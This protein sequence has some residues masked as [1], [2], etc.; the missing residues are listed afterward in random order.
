MKLAK[1]KGEMV[2]HTHDD[3]DEFFQVV[4]GRITIHLS[5][6]SV[7]LSEGECFIVPKGTA[8]MPEASEEAHVMLFEPKKT[9]H[10]G[11]TKSD[12]TVAIE[13]QEWI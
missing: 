5:E 13:D 2:W 3:E 11:T 10:T 12:L 9:A 6:E 7:E 8:H 1:L 4:K